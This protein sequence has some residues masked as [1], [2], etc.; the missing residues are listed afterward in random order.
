MGSCTSADPGA[1]LPSE[2]FAA[3]TEAPIRAHASATRAQSPVGLLEKRVVPVEPKE[4]PRA[5]IASLRDEKFLLLRRLHDAQQQEVSLRAQLAEGRRHARRGEVLWWG[6][7]VE[8][9]LR[10]ITVP[11][12][13]THGLSALIDS[14]KREGRISA[15]LEKRLRR[16]VL[17][18]NVAAHSADDLDPH[19]VDQFKAC[20]RD[21]L[22]DLRSR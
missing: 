18:R 1:R 10:A 11:R 15:K 20:A 14:G 3:A 2:P 19:D 5:T 6:I 9:R 21:T 16:L 22:S 13:K 4:D 12:G 7:Q 17:L 8:A